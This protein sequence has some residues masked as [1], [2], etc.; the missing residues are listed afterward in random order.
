MYAIVACTLLVV[1]FGSVAWQVLSRMRVP[2]SADLGKVPAVSVE[3]YRPMLRLLADEDLDFVQADNHLRKV[4]RSR[5]RQLFRS[6][7][8]CLARD[9]SLLLAGI[10]SVMVQSGIDRPDLARALARNR[11]L[12][13]ITMYKVEL[14]LALH[15]VGVG[16]VDISG[17]V[18][19]LEALRT[20]LSVL[21]AVPAAAASAA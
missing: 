13:A 1:V 12:F 11:A 15:A 7:L 19:T 18:D 9:Y 17:L 20:Q 10:R 2:A 6:Y 3:R 16:K 5:R 14:R 21:S 4:L 8:R